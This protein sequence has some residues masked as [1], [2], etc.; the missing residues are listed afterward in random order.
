[1]F[2]MSRKKVWNSIVRRKRKNHLDLSGKEESDAGSVCKWW[3]R[4]N[5]FFLLSLGF[6]FPTRGI[7]VNHEYIGAWIVAKRFGFSM[8]G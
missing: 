8:V 3:D 4:A 5:A 1:M 6:L 2:A 7:C